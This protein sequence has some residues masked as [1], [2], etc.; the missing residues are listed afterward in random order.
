MAEPS[1]LTSNPPDRI[2]ISVPLRSTYLSTLRTM[3]AS[4]GADVGFSIDEIDDVRL[5]IGEVVAALLES[6]PADRDV[7]V[8]ATFLTGGDELSVII[9]IPAS[10]T[11]VAFDDLALGILR[12]VVDHFEVTAEGVTLVKRATEARGSDESSTDR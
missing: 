1:V 6:T 4:L 3:A 11:T 8:T 9:P 10:G 5:G 2:E 7:R 12:S